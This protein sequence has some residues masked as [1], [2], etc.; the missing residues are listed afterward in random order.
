MKLA[1]PIFLKGLY[2]EKNI[3][4]GFR[5]AVRLPENSD[6][7]CLLE[8]TART[9]YRLYVDGQLIGHGPARAAHGHARVDVLDITAVM[10]KGREHML[11]VELAGYNDPN[12]YV[13]GESSF[14]MAEL[15]VG[16]T[17]LA[18]TDHSWQGFRLYQRRQLTEAF[19]HA[20]CLGETYDLDRSFIDWRTNAAEELAGRTGLEE[21]AERPVLLPRVVP[22]PDLRVARNARL[23]AVHDTEVD[24][25]LAVAAHPHFREEADHFHAF[26]PVV[27]RP[28]VACSQE[29]PL[30]FTGI[31]RLDQDHHFTIQPAPG[32]AAAL[33]YDFGEM[34]SGFIGIEFTCLEAGTLDLVFTDLL[35]DRGTFNP[36]RSGSNS[37][38]RLNSRPG[39]YTFV[40]FEPHAFRYVK[41]IVRGQ[42]F[43][44]HDLFTVLYQFQP[45]LQKAFLCNDGELNRIYEAAEKT[46]VMNAL[47]VFMDCPGR[48]RAGWLCDSYWSGRA[49]RLMLG[50]TSVE[51]AMLDNFLR[52][53]QAPLAEGFFPVCYPSGFANQGCFIPNWPL[54]LMLELDEYVC[55]SGD[56]QMLADYRQTVENL[57]GQFTR[58]ENAKGLLEN[59]PGYVFVEWSS[60][61]LEAY[62]SPISVGTNALYAHVLKRAG[63]IYRKPEWTDKADRLQSLLPSNAFTGSWYADSLRHDPERGLTPGSLFSEAVQYYMLRFVASERDDRP[64]MV[65]RLIEAHGP[66]APQLAMDGA[67]ARANV[68]IGYFLRFDLLADRGE[69]RR[70]LQEMR[71]LFS[72]MIDNGPGTLWEHTWSSDSVC[73]GFASHAGVWLV[74]DILGLHAP[75]ELNRTVRLAPHPCDL[76]WCKGALSCQGGTISVEW[77]RTESRFELMAHVPD[78]YEVLLEIPPPFAHGT[79]M[80][81]SISSKGQIHFI[82]NK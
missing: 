82:I 40:S 45:P 71:A 51:R 62:K 42:T 47:D 31:Q 68:F 39:R 8:I 2:L 16:D 22:L 43:T 61:N 36:R 57:I 56:T 9:F 81:K 60:A 18:Y 17:V 30:P 44:V 77:H 21:L 20:R 3:Q 65:R 49:A 5:K 67:L 53:D 73:H 14:L 52:S 66:A 28:S 64:E 80:D 29:I 41:L 69:H 12:V 32:R 35:E 25:N 76:K 24:P 46:L 4:A 75:D 50:D 33:A 70:L 1:K 79:R 26:P 11:A 37:V 63:D 74:R 15:T 58:Y 48:E 23:I 6:G 13:T 10:T 38:I 34:N 59:L 27:D 72:H 55:R 19:S 7:A 78:R 54:F